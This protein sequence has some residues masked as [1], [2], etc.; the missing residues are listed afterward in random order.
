MI[1][2][3]G[4]GKRYGHIVALDGVSLEIQPGETFGLLGP[5]GAGK[6]TFLHLLAGILAPDAGSV[7]IDG[8]VDPRNPAVRRKIGIAPQSISLYKELT[9]DENLHFFGRLYGLT[10]PKLRERVDDVLRRVGLTDRRGDTVGTYSGGMARRLNLGCALLHD[11]QVLLLDEPTVG[12]DPQS[13]NYLFE[14]VEALA[15]E[16]RTVLYTTHYMEEAQRLCDRVAIFD[17]GKVLALDSVDGLLAKY[18]GKAK[19]VAELEHAVAQ[20]PPGSN[21]QGLDLRFESDRPLDDLV[22]L[23]QADM[24]IRSFRVD[25]PDLENVF[26]TLTGRRLRDE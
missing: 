21:L 23:R 25:M 17:Q 14:T 12:V 15:A 19:V 5:N 3:Q 6:T 4:L 11:P 20:L 13:R 10:G 22:A 7:S 9:A 16:G 24:P 26:L 2:A 1:V 18:G 8:E